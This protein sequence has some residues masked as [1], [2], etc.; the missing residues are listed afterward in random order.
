MVTASPKQIVIEDQGPRDGF[1][2]EQT[3]VPTALKLELIGALVEAGVKRVQVTSFVHPKYVPQ[4][5][6]AEAVC[7]GLKPRDGVVY[8]GLVLNERGI[9]RAIA[10]GLSHVAASYSASNTHSQKNARVTLAQAQEN[11]LAI[12]R[13]AKGAGL[14]VRGGVQCAFGC[15]YEGHINPDAVLRMLES[16][17]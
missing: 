10:A 14:T 1:Q 8:S 2:S 12:V 15:R 5:A 4:M 3:V 6:D 16:S 11:Y 9:D 7:A 13:K 17:R